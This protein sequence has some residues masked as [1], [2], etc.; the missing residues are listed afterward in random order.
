LSDRTGIYKSSFRSVRTLIQ[1]NCK[2]Y[3][4][5]ELTLYKQTTSV[6]AEDTKVAP[7][8]LGFWK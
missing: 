6:G 5:N 4:L 8:E 3:V 7:V 2:F 1:S